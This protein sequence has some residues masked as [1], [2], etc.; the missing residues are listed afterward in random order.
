V[1]ALLAFAVSLLGVS[2]VALVHVERRQ[3][4][5]RAA[6]VGAAAANAVVDDL[7][8]PWN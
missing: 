2:L 7:V 1:H 3:P 8:P 4:V 6:R 5:P